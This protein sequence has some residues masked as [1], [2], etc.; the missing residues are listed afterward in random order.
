MDGGRASWM[1]LGLMRHAGGCAWQAAAA[2]AAA[3]SSGRRQQPAA[4]PPLAESTP[5]SLLHTYKQH[6]SAHFFCTAGM[7]PPGCTWNAPLT[8]PQLRL[9]PHLPV[10]VGCHGLPMGRGRPLLVCFDSHHPGEG[11]ASCVHITATF[12]GM[13][14]P[15]SVWM[16][17]C[18][19]A[20]VCAS[21]STSHQHTTH[22]LH[23]C[24]RP[25]SPAAST[26]P[27][28]TN[29]RTPA[30]HAPIQAG[31]AVCH[32]CGGAETQGTH[33]PHCVGDCA[34][35][36]GRPSARALSVLLPAHQRV[37]D[38][39]A[40][41]QRGNSYTSSNRLGMRGVER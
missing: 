29:A 24:W 11:W 30:T 3:A 4:T 23:T 28:S 7:P 19:C 39:D 2:V 22:T 6:S 31:A 36:L 40:A 14:M 18:V 13:C 10:P 41:G 25:N 9:L 26:L 34:C 16:T 5:P 20:C 32:P 27:P 1:L 33:Q 12:V 38:G 17:A 35:A 8:L 37:G 15:V 21:N